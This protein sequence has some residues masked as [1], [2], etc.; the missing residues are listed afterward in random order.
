MVTHTLYDLISQ[1]STAGTEID[2]RFY[3]QTSVRFMKFDRRIRFKDEL[4]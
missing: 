1:F 2:K 4:D 3:S